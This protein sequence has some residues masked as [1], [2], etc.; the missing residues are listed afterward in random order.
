MSSKR[1]LQIV[2]TILGIVPLATGVLGMLGI[3]DPLYASLGIAMPDDATLDSN[4]RF[5]AGVWFGLGLSVLYTIPDIERKGVLFRA[6]WLM[7]FVG[8]IGR[9]ISLVSVGAPFFPFIG[10]TVL[11]IVGAPLFVWWQSRVA[12]AAR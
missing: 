5:F 1:T 6:L 2:T 8:G 9:L 4:L 12:A 11:E 7:I 10:F 3:H